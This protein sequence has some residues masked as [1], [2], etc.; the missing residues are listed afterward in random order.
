MSRKCLYDMS[1]KLQHEYYINFNKIIL[2]NDQNALKDE[3]SK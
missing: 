2:G 3:G 1:S